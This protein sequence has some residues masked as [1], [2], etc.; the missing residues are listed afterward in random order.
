MVG[1]WVGTGAK[2][3]VLLGKETLSSLYIH[4]DS[5]V[6]LKK[7]C[8]KNGGACCRRQMDFIVYNGGGACSKFT[9][10]NHGTVTMKSIYTINVR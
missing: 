6:K 2:E 3:N 9:I 5:K 1:L 8:L 7:F 10:C 4:E